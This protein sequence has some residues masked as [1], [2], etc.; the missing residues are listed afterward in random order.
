MQTF[1]CIDENNITYIHL[2]RNLSN[3]TPFGKE[4]LYKK[5]FPKNTRLWE[6]KSTSDN[7]V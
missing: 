3:P 5:T 6:S 7:T 1:L 2:H 4:I